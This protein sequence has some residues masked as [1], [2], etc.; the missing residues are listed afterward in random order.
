[1][2]LQIKQMESGAFI[3]QTKYCL[4]LLKKYHMK[5]SKIISIL[6][7]LKLLI[8]KDENGLEIEITKYRGIIGFLLYLTSSIP[9]IIFNVCMYTWFRGI[10]I[11]PLITV[12]DF[13]NVTNTTL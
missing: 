4:E 3:C 10:L 9:Y 1:M 5:N 13:S 2:V 8:E 6:M 12:F 11:E 7:A